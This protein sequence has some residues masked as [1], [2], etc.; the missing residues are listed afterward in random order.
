M[1]AVQAAELMALVKAEKK[2]AEK[3]AD[4]KPLQIPNTLTKVGDKAMME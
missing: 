4:H 2:S 3:V 1:H